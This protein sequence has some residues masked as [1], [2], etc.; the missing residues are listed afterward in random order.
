MGPRVAVLLVM[1]AALAS[2]RVVPAQDQAPSATTLVVVIQGDTQYHQP[3]C[4]LVAKAG[5]KVQMMKLDEAAR[6]GLTAH[7]CEGA[8]I[9]Q[10]KKDANAIPVFV[11]PGDKHYHNKGCAKLGAGATTLAL[12]DAGRRYWPCPICKPPIRKRESK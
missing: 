12:G 3:G 4:P 10:P 2:P 7:D 8:A 5:S 9:D 6:R 11:Q 1:F